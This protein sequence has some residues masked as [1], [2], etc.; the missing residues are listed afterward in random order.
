MEPTQHELGLFH[1]SAPSATAAGCCLI[2]SFAGADEPAVIG[3]RGPMR[4]GVCVFLLLVHP[5]GVNAPALGG[6]K[7]KK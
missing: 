6:K 1:T 7:E 5:E 2:C 3:W 4:T